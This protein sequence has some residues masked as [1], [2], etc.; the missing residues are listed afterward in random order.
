MPRRGQFS[1]AVDKYE[2][3]MRRRD[4]E[5]VR[6]LRA[7]FSTAAE[8][9]AHTSPAV[10]IAGV[11][12][13]SA[14]ADDWAKL[15]R[16]NEVQVCVDVLCGYLRLP[17]S[18]ERGEQC[19]KVVIK[20]PADISGMTREEHFEYK[21]NEAHVRRT[22]VSVIAA[23]LRPSTADAEEVE[24]GEG[25][26]QDHEETGAALRRH[27]PAAECK[28][29]D[30]NFDFA[31]AQFE[32]ADF[33]K[34]VFN[35]D[36]T[37]ENAT[38]NGDTYFAE[39]RFNSEARFTRATFNGGTTTFREATFHGEDTNFYG[40]TF[41]S[42]DGTDFELAKFK[43]DRSIFTYATFNSGT[44]FSYAE[45]SNDTRFQGTKFYGDF[46]N[47]TFANFTE[48]TAFDKAE[49]ISDMGMVNFRWAWFDGWNT[50]FKQV[51]FDCWVADFRDPRKWRNVEF[52]WHSPSGAA[53]LKNLKISR[54][55]EFSPGGC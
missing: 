14:L 37:F 13:M 18:S 6:D 3:A 24:E 55:P 19:S 17:Y 29:S 41:N 22:I 10:R 39:A 16:S 9:L 21:Q 42:A 8:Q 31:G 46:T 7:R 1:R 34:A 36:T 25:E 33:Y 2:L 5:E 38:F 26:K 53:D 44:H 27:P 50:S 11:Y 43:S 52:D 47:F 12:A 48:F 30:C 51:T 32:D 49:F 40:V 54:S 4:D 45:I 23:H 35:G 20:R 28:W 15:G